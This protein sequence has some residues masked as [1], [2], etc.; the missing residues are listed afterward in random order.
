MKRLLAL[1]ALTSCSILAAQ[2]VLD[3]T[4][5]L[6]LAG[7]TPTLLQTITGTDGNVCTLT[8]EPGPN[9]WML[10]GCN[11]S[12]SG[13]Q[14]RTAQITSTGTTAASSI[15]FNQGIAAC[16]IGLNPTAAAVTMGS[17][18]SV[19]AKGAAWSCTPDMAT[20][21]TGTVTWP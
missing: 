5:I 20:I 6:Q 2:T 4:S 10:W 7:K 11:G 18:G 17:L 16:L 15:F 21:L 9:I 12:T 13:V 14:T 19:P 3:V 8:K 1:F